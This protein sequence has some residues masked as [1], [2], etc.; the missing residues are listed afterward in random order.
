[1]SNNASRNLLAVI[2]GGGKGT[3]LYP[4]TKYRAKPAVPVAG[5]FRIIDVTLSSCLN[6]NI[7]KIYVLTQFNTHSLHRHI[8]DTYQLGRFSHGFVD[9]LAAEQTAHN[10]DWYQGTAD[11]VRQNLHYITNAEADYTLILSGDHIYRMDY[12]KFWRFH[13]NVDA[14]VSISVQP[15]SAEEATSLGILKTDKNHKIIEF[16]EKPDEEQ[17]EDLKSPGLPEETPYLASMG[18]YLF[19]TRKLIEKLNEIDEDD[20]GHDII[21][22]TIKTDEVYAYRFNGY[23]KDIGTIQSFFETN[24]EI[25]SQ[26]PKFSFHDQRAPIYTRARSLPGT[27]IDNGKIVDSYIADGGS[28]KD[29]E[30]RNSVVGLRSQ[31]DRGAKLQNVILM[32]EDYYEKEPEGNLP[33]L[34]IGKNCLIKNAIIDKNVRIGDNVKII[35]EDN[36]QNK[37]S[38]HW[39]IKDGIIV[40]P[41]N[42]IIRSGSVI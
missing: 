37:K 26:S 9:I 42:T 21:P 2:L 15:V 39:E 16:V 1:M 7:R 38:D 23:W 13:K 10:K 30:L 24:L 32:G 17:L 34:G 5:K 22:P 41:K 28:L 4:L 11:A 19:N 8:Y 29:C 25:A 27:R 20:F 6:S 40:I 3:R 12:R 35:N 31:I 18:I 33:E 14:N 36:I